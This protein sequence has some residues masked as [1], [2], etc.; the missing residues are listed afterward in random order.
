[1][2]KLH[3]PI[4][5][6]G[7]RPVRHKDLLFVSAL[8]GDTIRY[9]CYHPAEALAFA[10]VSSDVKV[11][12][13]VALRDQ[14][15]RYGAFVLHR[16]PWD[17]EV[18]SFVEEARQ[19]GRPVLFD[20]DDLVFEPTIVRNGPTNDAHREPLPDEIRR[21]RQT[22]REA[23]GVIVSTE[24]LAERA[25]EQNTN[26]R[27]IHN[28]VSM[29]MVAHADEILRKPAPTDGRVTITYAAGTPTHD[30]DFAEVADAILAT[31]D[32]Q[33]NA[34]FVGIGHVRV[35]ERFARYHSQVKLLPMQKWRDLPQ[36]LAGADVNIAPLEPDSPF[37]ESKSC[38][39]YLEAGL[40]GIP[41]IASPRSDF[42][43]A[44]D[45]GVNGVLAEGRAAWREALGRLVE[46]APARRELG[47]CAQE[48]VRRSHTT[49]ACFR[50]MCETLESL[51]L[52][53]RRIG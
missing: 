41:T 31:L 51:R 39:K 28:V 34:Y 26:V 32:E 14:L 52:P 45:D 8:T 50:S 27:V 38:I 36:V 35:D 4:R 10:G 24:F 29:E 3:T 2:A 7:W 21:L 25:R 40:L 5:R 47:S 15:D 33:P 12:R 48:D 22:L 53:A 17:D 9:R 30:R 44:I 18:S 43:R 20:S 6:L 23:D 42:A 11:H 19:R 49:A 37:T 1:V 13:H 46:S 16:V